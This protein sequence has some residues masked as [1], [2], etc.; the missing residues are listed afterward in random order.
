MHI[1]RLITVLRLMHFDSFSLFF[2]SGE[3]SSCSLGDM[4]PGWSHIDSGRLFRGRILVLVFL[5]SHIHWR[6][7]KNQMEVLQ[8]SIIIHGH[9]QAL[10]ML[11]VN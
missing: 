3:G 7:I 5:V 9:V 4:L 10:Y 1:W 6:R 11:L 8:T 2:W